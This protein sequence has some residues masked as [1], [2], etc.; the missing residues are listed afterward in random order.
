MPNPLVERFEKTRAE[1]R[2]RTEDLRARTEDLRH[3]AGA[4]VDHGRGRLVQ[5]EAQ[6]LETAADALGRARET[7]GERADFVRRGEEA[8]REAL[9]ALRAG[10]EATLPVA[11]YAEL[12]VKQVQAAL[13]ALDSAGLRTVRAFEVQ[14]KARVTILR[15]IDRRLESL[16]A[17]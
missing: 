9:V 16:A 6:V 12:N 5:A 11:G 8:L 10:H 13:G 15:D 1:L 14:H 7:L 17:S 4:R 3:R 2:A